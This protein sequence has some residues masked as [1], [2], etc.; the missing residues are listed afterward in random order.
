ML[1]GF[2]SSVFR[3]RQQFHQFGIMHQPDVLLHGE[4][5]RVVGDFSGGDVDGFVRL[6][7]PPRGCQFLERL[8]AG[9]RHFPA[10]AA[11]QGSAP[12]LRKLK[13]GA[14]NL[15]PVH[16][17]AVAAEGL[18]QRARKLFP[19]QLAQRFERGGD[20][21]GAGRAQLLPA[22]VAAD[23]EERQRGE[24]RVEREIAGQD[25]AREREDPGGDGDADPPR[26]A[27]QDREQRILVQW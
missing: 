22:G 10:L 14:G 12:G 4:G 17:I 11:D 21:L 27:Q 5:A 23:D 19:G 1:I 20:A 8:D 2:S 13:I 24:E 7:P 16:G 6:A 25:G 18:L 26:R 9:A 15:Q 3:L